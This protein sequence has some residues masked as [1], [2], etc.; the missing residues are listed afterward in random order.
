MI[1]SK[2]YSNSRW[3]KKSLDSDSTQKD[4]HEWYYCYPQKLHNQVRKPGYKAIVKSITKSSKSTPQ[5][6]STA[7][8]CCCFLNFLS[9]SMTCS[10]SGK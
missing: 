1:R 9:P 3:E 5:Q 2:K 6:S 4:H 8:Q 7:G 10:V